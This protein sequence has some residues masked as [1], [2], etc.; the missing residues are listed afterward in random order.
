MNRFVKQRQKFYPKPVFA[1]LW[2]RR[3]ETGL[4]LIR[5]QKYEIAL[6]ALRYD[7]KIATNSLHITVSCALPRVARPT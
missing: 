6:A 1:R 4:M 3:F 2:P 7:S 5:A